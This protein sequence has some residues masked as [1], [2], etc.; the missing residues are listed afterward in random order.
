MKPG[1]ELDAIIAERVMGLEVLGGKIVNRWPHV[2]GV[3]TPIETPNY[4]TDIAAAWSV[5]EKLR[6]KFQ[7]GL[8]FYDGHHECEL[9][10]IGPDDI[11]H[12]EIYGRSAESAPHAICLAAIAALP[13]DPPT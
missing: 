5:V 6:D 9:N 11:Y 3:Y 7:V 1:K 8:T 13:K 10:E 12:P 2:P 4:S